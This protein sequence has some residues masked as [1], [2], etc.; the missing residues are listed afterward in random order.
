MLPHTAAMRATRA[1]KTSLHSVT[2]NEP[3]IPA[4]KLPIPVQKSQSDMLNDRMVGGAHVVTHDSAVGLVKS[5]P[6]VHSVIAQHTHSG[7]IGSAMLAPR[8]S[9]AYAPLTTNVPIVIFIS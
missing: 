6:V 8:A 4:R 3:N 1:K 7:F 2:N 9:T 5:S